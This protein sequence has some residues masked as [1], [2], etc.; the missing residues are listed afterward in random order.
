MEDQLAADL[1]QC[2][3]K[4]L[5]SLNDSALSRLAIG[6]G[7]SGPEQ[8]LRGAMERWIKEDLRMRLPFSSRVVGG[9]RLRRLATSVA[10]IVALP[11]IGVGMYTATKGL[12]AVSRADDV[13]ADRTGPSALL[14][15]DDASSRLTAQ[16][17]QAKFKAVCPVPRPALPFNDA[18]PRD[19]AGVALAFNEALVRGD[20]RVIDRLA[21]PTAGVKAW[22]HTETSAGM[23]VAASKRATSDERIIVTCG[24]R[25]AE[26]SWK[27]IVHDSNGVTAKG[28]ATFYLVRLEEGWRVWGSYDGGW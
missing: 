9:I 1:L 13:G 18:T 25:V 21:A 23:V 27:V 17:Y 8:L 5:A 28:V 4:A 22:G 24:P 16:R 14:P 11:L 19:A 6:T 12:V 2:S 3:T 26:R 20:A 7:S 10:V 15:E